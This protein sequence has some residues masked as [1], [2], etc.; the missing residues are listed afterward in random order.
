M[1][2]TIANGYLLILVLSL[3]VWNIVSVYLLCVD[4]I[5]AEV[6]EKLQAL[7]DAEFNPVRPHKHNVAR[8]IEISLLN[9]SYIAQDDITKTIKA[10]AKSRKLGLKKYVNLYLESLL[11]QSQLFNPCL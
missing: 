3:T 9:S 5:V 10:V 6:T 7:S 8:L 4:Q 2:F 11:E 1:V